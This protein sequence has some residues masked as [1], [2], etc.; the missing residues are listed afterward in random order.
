MDRYMTNDQAK[1]GILRSLTLPPKKYK[2]KKK[3]EPLTNKQIVDVLEHERVL[4]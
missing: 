3:I 2:K 4:K 1:K